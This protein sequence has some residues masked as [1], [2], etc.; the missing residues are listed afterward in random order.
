MDAKLFARMFS[1]SRM[2]DFK[3]LL[4]LYRPEDVEEFSSLLREGFCRTLPILDSGGNPIFYIEGRARLSASAY[5]AL[6]L[7][8]EETV[9]SVREELEESRATLSLDGI[10]YGRDATPASDR[11]E[12]DREERLRGVRRGIEFIG[13]I[14]RGITVENIYKLY[15]IAVGGPLQHGNYYRHGEPR[16][17]SG[18]PH[19]QLPRYMRRLVAFIGS[20]EGDNDLLKAAAIHFYMAYLRPYFEGSGIMARLAQAWYLSRRGYPSA[21][22][23]PISG[24]I[25]RSSRRY[26]HATAM[27]RRNFA[28]CGVTD[29]TSVLAYFAD[30]VY[31]VLPAGGGRSANADIYR[32]ALEEGRVTEKERD[33]WDFV[34]SAYGISD[35]STKRLEKDFGHAAYATIRGFVMKFE[36]MKLLS[37]K[38]FGNRVRYRVR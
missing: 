23:I 3:K 27:T 15:T 6:L 20:E 34:R 26:R 7:P 29:I 9:P 25:A 37:S 18:V 5:R 13:D 10:I 21:L 28:I 14:S 2:N 8:Y 36:R 35:F 17:R 19:S 1:G 24:A 38:K 11:D 33:L 30:N 32:T 31:N 22:N 4:R 12:A 16:L